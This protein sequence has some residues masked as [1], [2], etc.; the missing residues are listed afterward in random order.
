MKIAHVISASLIV[1]GGLIIYSL[2]WISHR[3]NNRALVLTYLKIAV[4]YTWIMLTLLILF[5]LISGFSMISSKPYSL[6]QPWIIATIVGFIGFVMSL[7]CAAT[8]LTQ[9]YDLLQDNNA[10]YH[11][12]AY[13]ISYQRFQKTI[14]L[15]LI[16]VLITLFFMINRPPF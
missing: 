12:E 1:G 10:D 8:S 4:N 11:T 14:G 6:H 3:Q 7:F 16:F 15:T 13:A 5:Q 2:V 9:C